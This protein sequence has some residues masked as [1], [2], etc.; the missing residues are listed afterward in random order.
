MRFRHKL[1][2]TFTISVISRTSIFREASTSEAHSSSAGLKTTL[3]SL[4]PTLQAQISGET[5]KPS[6]TKFRT[7]V[8]QAFNFNHL[9]RIMKIRTKLI[10]LAC[11][12]FVGLVMTHLQAQAQTFPD[13]PLKMVVGFVPGGLNDV[14]GRLIARELS[15]ALGQPVV[16]ENRPG[17]AGLLGAAAVAHAKPDGY[18]LL[19]ASSGSATIGPALAP[20]LGFDPRKGLTG[21][22]LVGDSANVLMVNSGLPYKS[23]RD[24][25]DAAR[26]SPGALTYASSGTG[27]T[28]HM[29]GALFANT[30]DVTILHVPYKGNAPAMNDIMA[31]Q[32]QMGF[33]GI[34]AALSA[35]QTG[36]VRLLAVTSN[37]RVKALP[38]V[39]TIR[40]AGLPKYSFSNWFGVFTTGGTNREVVARLSREIETILKKPQVREALLAQGVEARSLAPEAL[41]K[42]VDKELR[43]WAA[44]VK[45]TGITSD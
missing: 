22:S 25:I 6:G 29:S 39:P 40:E 20:K 28:L 15:D 32:V 8:I 41:N 19:L 1:S 45:A 33:A 43:E 17:A 13:K 3:E 38:D 36:K 23:V 12:T 34:P 14:L 9:E 30:A 5:D 11:S 37:T 2:L 21:I 27:S 24:V 35:Q 10:A 44:L 18:T 42:Q 4:L 26:K 31:G 7:T 16:V